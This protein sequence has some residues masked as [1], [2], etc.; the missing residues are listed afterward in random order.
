MTAAVIA[1]IAASC[2]AV[3]VAVAAIFTAFY[4][5]GIN[6]GRQTEIL[7]QLAAL[8]ADHEA[9]LRVLEQHRR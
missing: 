4:K 9:R 6:E 3:L 8:G 1:S 5:R 2:V 7:S